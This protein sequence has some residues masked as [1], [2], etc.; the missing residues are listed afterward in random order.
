[1]IRHQLLTESAS[2]HH[3]T[4]AKSLCPP[5]F[6]QS[7]TRLWFRSTRK[8]RQFIT[9][10]GYTQPAILEWVKSSTLASTERRKLESG[11]ELRPVDVQTTQPPS[12]I[13]VID[14]NSSR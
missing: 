13:P 12:T 3:I 5:A 1:M 10:C 4:C 8:R 2:T 14:A 11:K 9:L 7:G 6:L